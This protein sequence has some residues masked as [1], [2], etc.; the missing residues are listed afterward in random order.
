M[1]LAKDACEFYK[2]YKKPLVLIAIVILAY[3]LYKSSIMLEGYLS[4]SHPQC[5][6]YQKC[7]DCVKNSNA[8]DPTVPC[9]W[10]N[11]KDKH[12]NIKGCSAFYDPGYSRSCSEPTPTPTSCDKN[13][14]CQSCI[15][16]NCF[17]GDRD[18]KCSST[19]KN[20]Y[21]TICSGSNPE[22]APAPCPICTSC[23]T[24]TILKTPTFITA[25]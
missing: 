19:S 15:S 12:G 1:N 2:K 8:G 13:T 6:T 11:D 20:G 5:S 14:N 24:L 9:W 4:Q 18:Q 10:S 21:G 23:P 3:Y 25:Q 7:S 17:W 22:P 16:S